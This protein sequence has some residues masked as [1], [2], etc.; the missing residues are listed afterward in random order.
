V[1][2]ATRYVETEEK[3]GDVVIEVPVARP[4]RRP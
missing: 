4:L 1:V 2:E 3:T